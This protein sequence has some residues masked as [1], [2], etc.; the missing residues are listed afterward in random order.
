MTRLFDICPNDETRKV[1]YCENCEYFRSCLKKRLKE[2]RE[3][4]ENYR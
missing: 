2:E 4:T 3:N 1:E